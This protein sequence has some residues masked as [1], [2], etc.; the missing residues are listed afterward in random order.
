[1]IATTPIVFSS[2]FAAASAAP[3]CSR[4][5]TIGTYR[6]STS[7]YRQN[8]SQHTWTLE[9]ITRFGRA[10]RAWQRPCG[11]PASATAG[12]SRRACRP[13]STRW[14]SSRPIV[15][16]RWAFHRLPRMFTQR[17]SSSAVCGYSSLSIMF[18]GAHSA[19]SSSASGSIHVVTN[20]ARF[21][22]ALPSRI[23]S[24]RT[25]CS[26]VRGSMLCS[27]SR[28]RGMSQAL[29]AEVD[30]IDLEFGVRGVLVDL[31]VQ[32]HGTSL[33]GNRSPLPARPTGDDR[34]ERDA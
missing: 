15:R 32:C 10:A 33:T 8:F 17:L 3:R 14:S 25:T 21:S 34:G 29:L 20:V 31:L 30:G 27:G 16:P 12:P 6:G 13:R 9:P 28:Y 1:M 4:P 5:G 22:L 19:I 7:Q 18:L 23:S 24:S 2:H 11:G 26:A